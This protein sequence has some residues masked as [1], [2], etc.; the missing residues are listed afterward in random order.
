M[1]PWNEQSPEL[2]V[3]AGVHVEVLAQSLGLLQKELSGSTQ[4]PLYW[5]HT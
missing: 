4:S 3:P 1:Q 2:H 5:S